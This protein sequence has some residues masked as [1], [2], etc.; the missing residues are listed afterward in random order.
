[1]FETIEVVR[2]SRVAVIWMNRPEVHHAVNEVMVKELTEAMR[3][4]SADQEVSAIV[5]ASRGE[6][7][8][9]GTDLGWYQRAW[10]E[11]GQSDDAPDAAFAELLKVIDDV[12]VPVI[13][14][15]HGHCVGTGVGLVAAADIAVAS[16]EA[17]FTQAETR[18]GMVPR[19]VA[20]YLARAIGSRQAGRWLM[21]GE[22]L[23]AA[24]A[25]RLGLVHEICDASELDA[26]INGILGHL[27]TAELGAVMSTRKLVKSLDAGSGQK[28]ASLQVRGDGTT[29]S[30]GDLAQ[31]GVAAF[32]EKRW[33]A[34]APEEL[35]S[36]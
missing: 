32:L 14:R 24:E 36:P 30:G 3:D 5:L 12:Q 8:C 13:V 18:L 1:M 34:W 16:H 11:R 31:E 23:S 6:S 19:V 22:T 27:M 4:A 21:T 28:N 15:V 9:S 2:G 10:H 25:W 20:P 33:P 35:K 26:R 7:F 29:A 17:E